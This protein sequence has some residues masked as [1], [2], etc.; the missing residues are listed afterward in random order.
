MSCH[1]INKLI[2]IVGLSCIFNLNCSFGQVKSDPSLSAGQYYFRENGCVDIGLIFGKCG[3][4][5]YGVPDQRPI[6]D[7]ST[8]GNLELLDSQVKELREIYREGV[9]EQF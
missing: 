7:K 3:L 2:L 4:P 9:V 6:Y 1:S 5:N 8:T